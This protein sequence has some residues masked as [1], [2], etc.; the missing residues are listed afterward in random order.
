MMLKSG[1]NL[2]VEPSSVLATGGQ[3]MAKIN[4]VGPSGGVT[5]A[6]QMIQEVLIK[7]PDKLSALP[8]APQ[9]YGYD[10]PNFNQQQP[11]GPLAPPP[12]PNG[13]PG[14]GNCCLLVLFV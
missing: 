8:D 3:E 14:R 11:Q 10:N 13:R 6:G 7:G 1:A 2:E 12:P 4:L 9:A 5:L